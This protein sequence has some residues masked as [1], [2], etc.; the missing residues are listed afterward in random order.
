MTPD[1]YFTLTFYARKPKTEKS[2]YPLY[3]RISV[4]GQMTEFTIGRSVNPK[5]WNQKRNQS[6]GTSRRDKEL[7]KFLEMV[8][9]RFCEIHNM[10]IRENKLVNPAVLKAH[11]MG[12]M[13]KPKMMCEVFR[14]A[15]EKRKEEL[16][17]GDIV[18][19][20]YQRWT[21]CVD[22][23]EDFFKLHY[24][25][26]D[27]PIK[28]VTSGMLD[29]FEHFLRMKKSCANNAAVRYLRCVKNV[30]QYALAHKWIDH[31][32]FIGK[33]Y[34]RTYSERQ[35]LTEAEIKTIMDLDLKELPRLEVV[36]DTFVF[37]CFSGLAFCDMKSLTI[38]DI[39]DDD[40][41]NTWIRK[42][43]AKTGEMCIIPMLD[44]PRQLIKKYSDHPVVKA[45]GVV[46]PV[47]TNQK[48]N[49]YLKEI[50][51]LAKIKKHLTTHVARH[52]SHTSINLPATNCIST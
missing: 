24:K 47:I 30:L 32:P 41:G 10:L 7:N 16:D 1:S 18:K 23:L 51:D 50:A 22:Y 28:E 8:R 27:I 9:A 14:E 11:Y 38:D 3:A 49:A 42:A 35:F 46:M 25:T 33:K 37:C 19:P 13:E 34:Q 2:E 29:D 17:R 44:I 31:D 6:D 52:T 40:K 26:D 12:T 15:N 39:Q 45:T 21:R 43:R 48:M 5:H 4:G 36:R 20:T